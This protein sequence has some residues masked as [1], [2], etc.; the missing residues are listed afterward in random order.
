MQGYCIQKIN[1][2]NDR[3]FFLNDCTKQCILK[4]AR[5]CSNAINV[6]SHKMALKQYFLRNA[7]V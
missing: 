1:N 3:I 7:T 2:K 5:C 4:P 6:R